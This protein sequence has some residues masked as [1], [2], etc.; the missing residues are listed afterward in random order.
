MISPSR[1]IRDTV[2][3][4][5]ALQRR[6]SMMDAN[7]GV[8]VQVSGLIW[9]PARYEPTT[10][11]NFAREMFFTTSTSINPSVGS[12]VGRPLKPPPQ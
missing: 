1:Q 11:K 2:S 5:N 8:T 3:K 4:V 12:A 6:Y 7:W 9:V 10:D